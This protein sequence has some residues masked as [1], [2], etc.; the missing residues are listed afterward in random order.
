MRGENT[1]IHIKAYKTKRWEYLNRIKRTKT[2]RKN[3]EW[4][5]TGMRSKVNELKLKS[6][7]YIAEDRKAWYELVQKTKT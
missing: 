7:A 5:P 2:V 3:M 6:C 4:T 1:V